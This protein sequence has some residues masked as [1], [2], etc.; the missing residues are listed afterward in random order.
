[1]LAT[2]G[3]ALPA[4]TAQG[5]VYV[6][7]V[8][9]RTGD[10]YRDQ[11][12]SLIEHA[13]TRHELDPDLIRAIVQVESN[14][15]PFAVSPKGARGLMQLIPATARRFGV[16]DPFDPRS[17]LDGGARYLKY[18]MGLFGGDLQL[19]LAAYNAGEEAVARR[20]G[21]PPYRETRNYLRKIG[22]IYPLRNGASGTPSAPRIIKSVDQRGVAH[23]SN[24]DLP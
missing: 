6:E 24:T 11:I 4:G 20:K 5:S 9:T 14:Y 12:H 16:R 19:S 22:Q 13:A 15:N 3:E 18:L 8:P 7:E 21:V 1:V 17:N 23:F 10:L 2:T